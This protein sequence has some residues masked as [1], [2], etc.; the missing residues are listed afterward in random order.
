MR[1]IITEPP[2]EKD[3]I[4]WNDKFNLGIP[5]I[6]EQHKTLV[7]LCNDLYKSLMSPHSDSDEWKLLVTDA[8]KECVNYVQIHFSSEEKLQLASGFPGYEE[9]K[10]RHEEFTRKILEL[11]STIS[12]SSVQE[13]IKFVKYLYDW[14]LTH[15]AHEDRQF[16]PYIAEYIKQRQN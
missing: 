12:T 4:Q 15:I 2:E 10:K 11:S 9:H 7:K 1:R 13:G 6:D 3:Y 5:V 16:L 14:I 8:L